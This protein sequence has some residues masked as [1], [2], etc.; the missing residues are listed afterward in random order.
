MRYHRPMNEKPRR[1][2]GGGWAVLASAMVLL[3][4]LYV[5]S[6]GP[7]YWLVWHGHISSEAA[8]AASAPLEWVSDRSVLVD[9][10]LALYIRLRIPPPLGGQSPTSA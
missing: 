7:A 1:T 3:P 2:R 6:I 5:L 9:R 10:L 4:I 8:L